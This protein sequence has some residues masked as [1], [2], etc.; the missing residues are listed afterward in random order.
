MD[1]HPTERRS[2]T[3][4]RTGFGPG[5]ARRAATEGWRDGHGNRRPSGG[6]ASAQPTDGRKVPCR[7]RKR[8]S[9]TR[10]TVSFGPRGGRPAA[11]EV[12]RPAGRPRTPA[13][14]CS[15]T[16]PEG[17][18]A[19]TSSAGAT[20]ADLAAGE[21]RRTWARGERP[22]ISRGWRAGT[23]PRRGRAS[24][25]QRHGHGLER[26]WKERSRR[27]SGTR[28]LGPPT[29]ASATVAV[30]TGVS[31][32]SESEAVLRHRGVIRRGGRVT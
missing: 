2:R 28:A 22:P 21:L 24:A 20:V 26:H 6:C 32:S 4:Q 18:K 30:V 12:V 25:R 27:A 19:Y 8:A 15:G 29:R 9:T 3:T 14:T 23:G 1:R 7:P 17:T 11:V 16:A 10:H 31:S 5:A 13:V